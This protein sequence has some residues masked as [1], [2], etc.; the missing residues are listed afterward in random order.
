MDA[1]E[2][3]MAAMEA[4]MEAME[5]QME[6]D[7]AEMS[8]MDERGGGGWFKRLKKRGYS[9]DSEDGL[10]HVIVDTDVDTDDQMAIAYLLAQPDI[11]VLAITV[12]CNGWSQQ[13][14]GV[15]SIMRLTKYFGQPDIPVA[16][17]PLYNP[18]TQLN[19]NEPNGLPD[20]T[21][22]AGKGNFLSEF[23][24]LPFNIRPPSW[25]Y[26]GQLLKQTLSKSRKQVDILALGPL[27]NLAHF[28]QESP[29]LFKS[30]VKRIYNSGG[31]VVSR[32][33][34]PTDKVWPY[35]APNTS[36]T[37]N[38]PDTEWNIFSDPVAANSV[39]SF[40]VSIVLAT[41]T[42]TDGMQFYLNDTD[43]IPSSCDSDKADV[44]TKMVTTLPTADGEDPDDLRYWDESAMVLFVQML[45]NGGKAEAAVCTEWDK[46]RF[47][48]MLEAG[49][50]A[51][52]SGGQYARLLQNEFGQEATECL[53]GNLTEFKLAYFEGFCSR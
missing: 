21:L 47:A 2:A 5:A 17:S 48:V 9:G 11:K 51:S 49:N 14:A 1:M 25:M 16:F 6:G 10:T 8:S 38:P 24:G 35:S 41:S 40:G 7:M 50:N 30:K 18:D 13:W 36:F 45:R 15:M 4:H 19:L 26:T 32:S 52:V 20:P 23:V 29:K 53:T 33:S 44:L 3:R 22:L 43:F 39:L 46:K 42:Y 28:L 12:G 27:T 37:G 34:D 31:T